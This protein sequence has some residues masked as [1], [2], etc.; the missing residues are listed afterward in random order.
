[1]DE[2]INRGPS[3]IS[4][5]VPVYNSEA[6]IDVLVKRVSSSLE[7]LT[8]QYEIWLVND[9]SEDGSWRVISHLATQFPQVHGLN[10]SRN[11]G[12]HLALIAGVRE[13]QME[14]VVTLDDD[15]AQPPEWIE[16]LLSKAEQGY[17]LVFGIPASERNRRVRRFVSKAAQVFLAPATRS[18][19]TSAPF[20]LFRRSLCDSFSE[21]KSR[22]LTLDILLNWV[23][24]RV[25][26][27]PVPYSETSGRPSRHS[28]SS[29]IQL[30][31]N[32]LAGLTLWPLRLIGFSGI[33][34]L[35]SSLGLVGWQGT[36]WFVGNVVSTNVVFASA[37]LFV[38][39]LQ[40]IALGILGEYLGRTYLQ[41]LGFPG[42]WV[43]EKV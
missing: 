18:G 34:F 26:S 8:D 22:Y 25:T 33:L 40:S 32:G 37:I 1:M 30:F 41:S 10:L 39:G 16:H 24:H 2:I 31:S 20:R 29:L 38:F 42:G 15:L 7:K 9:G 36:Q 27:V 21:T 4:V 19:V 35:M 13:C 28:W 3:S 23:A 12:Q 43:R 17:D 5:V 11:F 6:S 14:W